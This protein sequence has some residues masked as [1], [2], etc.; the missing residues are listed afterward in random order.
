MKMARLPPPRC[1]A[2]LVLVLAAAAAPRPCAA[3]AF[4]SPA[5]AEL[6]RQLAGGLTALSKSLVDG[7]PLP[8]P[9][10]APVNS[11]ARPGPA[12]AAAGAKAAGG[13]AVAP[14]GATPEAV[15]KA[16]GTIL[17]AASLEAEVQSTLGAPSRWK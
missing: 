5:E 13:G 16:L 15:A 3:A 9:P 8:D 14:A 6:Y 7:T 17:A 11:T 12:A 2:A 1:A 10:Q 4:A